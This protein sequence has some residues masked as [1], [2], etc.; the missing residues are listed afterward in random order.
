MRSSFHNVILLMTDTQVLRKS[1]GK[2]GG[3]R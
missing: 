3:P 2:V 1:V